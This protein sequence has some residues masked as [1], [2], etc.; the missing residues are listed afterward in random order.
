MLVVFFFTLLLGAR[1][2]SSHNRLSSANENV[3]Y[4]RARALFPHCLVLKK[5]KSKSKFLNVNFTLSRDSPVEISEA[6]N[7]EVVEIGKSQFLKLRS[8]VRAR[9]LSRVA[10]ESCDT[11]DTPS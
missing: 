3:A 10:R 1:P 2:L 11:Y 7:L 8:A 6:A 5:K 9:D 4:T